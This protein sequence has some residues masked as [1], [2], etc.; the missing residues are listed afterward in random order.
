MY[1]LI[2]DSDSG[3][4]SRDWHFKEAIKDDVKI[5]NEKV[6]MGIPNFINSGL[7]CVC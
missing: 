1:V 5:T 6:H 2:D 4:R 3:K 7:I